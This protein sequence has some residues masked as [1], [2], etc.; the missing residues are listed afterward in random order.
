MVALMR[1]PAGARLPA[2]GWGEGVGVPTEMALPPAG[3][4]QG[5]LSKGWRWWGLDTPSR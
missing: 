1:G 3:L 5:H 2:L 4:L